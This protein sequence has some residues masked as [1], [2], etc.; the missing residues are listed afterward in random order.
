MDRFLSPYND[1]EAFSNITLG[2]C[3]PDGKELIMSGIPEDKITKY[4]KLNI[5]NKYNN[6]TGKAYLNSFFK[7]YLVTYYMSVPRMDVFA[8]DFQY[9]M[10]KFNYLTDPYSLPL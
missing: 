8:K 3:V 4:F 2:Y 10:T 7:I 9:E 5:Y 6:A 1:K